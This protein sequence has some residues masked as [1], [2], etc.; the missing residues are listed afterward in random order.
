M[1]K[2]VFYSGSSFAPPTRGVYESGSRSNYTELEAFGNWRRMLSNF[3]TSETFTWDGNDLGFKFAPGTRWRSIEHVFQGAK[4]SLVSLYH[5]LRFTEEYGGF[6]GNGDGYLAKLN[7]R[8]IKL[9]PAQLSVWDSLKEAVMESAAYAKYT[10]NIN[11]TWAK[12]LRSTKNA[13][14]WHIQRQRGRDQVFLC[15]SPILS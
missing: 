3:D 4:L 12:M 14:L 1:E 6:L 9:S 7:G 15:V 2:L 13:E 11:G 10:Q 8:L 5:G